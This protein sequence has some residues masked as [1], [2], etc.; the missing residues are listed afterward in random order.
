MFGVGDPV[1]L[2]ADRQCAYVMQPNQNHFR[3]LKHTRINSKSMRSEEFSLRK[4]PEV[5][6]L[7]FVGDSITFGTTQIDQP[8]IFTEILRRELPS[9]VHR[10]IEVLNASANAWAIENELAYVESRGIFQSD[11]VVLVLNNGDLSQP[12]ST[13]ADVGTALYFSKPACALCELAD[14]YMHHE[15]RDRGTAEGTN[16][17]QELRN[18]KKLDEFRKLVLSSGA[19]MV[20]LFVPFPRD[21]P[22]SPNVLQPALGDW[23]QSHNVELI[24]ATPFL[25]PLPI[26][27]ASV[28]G[29]HLS[30]KGNRAVATAFEQSAPHL[31]S[32]NNR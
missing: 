32:A 1:L 18:L 2:Q 17:A 13:T 27:A 24:D 9:T 7:M 30:A 11:R 22:R 6:R 14:R 4:A 8:E 15:K 31:V 21:I 20:I 23:A 3:L 25:S 28:D 10:H 16:E 19:D 26:K 12:V 5:Y 29:L